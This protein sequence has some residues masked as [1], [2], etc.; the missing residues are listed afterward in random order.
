MVPLLQIVHVVLTP[1]SDDRHMLY[2]IHYILVPVGVTLAAQVI[3]DQLH[4]CVFSNH[5]V[6]EQTPG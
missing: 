4:G 1:L 5:L 3:E 6:V 2:V